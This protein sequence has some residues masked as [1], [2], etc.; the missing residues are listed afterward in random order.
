MLKQSIKGE[1][2]LR[3][4][5]QIKIWINKFQFVLGSEI[6]QTENFWGDK[7]SEWAGFSEKSWNKKILKKY[8][9][10]KNDYRIWN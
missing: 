7:K 8:E 10:Q 3:F 4:E 2:K 5:K 1:K 9:K 6:N